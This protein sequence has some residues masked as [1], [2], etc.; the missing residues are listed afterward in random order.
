MSQ[1]L[2]SRIR[3]ARLWTVLY[4]GLV[5]VI[6]ALPKHTSSRRRPARRSARPA[7]PSPREQNNDIP[8]WLQPPEVRHHSDLAR[9]PATTPPDTT[10]RFGIAGRASVPTEA[11]ARTFYRQFLLPAPPPNTRVITVFVRGARSAGK[12]TFIRTICDSDV[13]E[14]AQR[15][16]PHGSLSIEDFG[17]IHVHDSLVLDLIGTTNMEH[18]LQLP[19]HIACDSYGGTIFLVDGTSTRYF[20]GMHQWWERARQH[21]PPPY[22]T[23]QTKV[24]TEHPVPPD[25]LRRFANI[26]PDEFLMPCIATSRTSVHRVVSI[27]LDGILRWLDA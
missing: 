9:R 20:H 22:I 23:V 3:S 6:D 26:P 21:T 5:Q 14:I 7:A 25:Q 13:R 11:Q 27:F 18:D 2:F 15:R 24:D 16:L 4:R 10:R 8:D 17:R 19:P 12:T 1:N